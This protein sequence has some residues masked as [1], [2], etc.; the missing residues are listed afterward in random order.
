[1]ITAIVES[2]QRDEGSVVVFKAAP[3]DGSYEKH[4][5]FA[6]D[7]RC[8]QDIANALDEGEEPLVVLEDWQILGG[9]PS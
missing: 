8:A 3:T 2:I 7:H 1:M 9:A 4:I 6:C 5:F